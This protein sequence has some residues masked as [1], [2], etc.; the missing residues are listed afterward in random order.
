MS[1]YVK[2]TNFLRKD[3]L[4]DT[5]TDKIIRGS[6]FDTE[7][8]NL[9]TAVASKANTVSPE[10]TG[11]PRA[12]TASTGTSS[13]QIATTAFVTQNAILRGMI[14]MWSGAVDTIPAGYALC[15]GDNDTPDLRNRFVVGAGSTYA[16]DATG[17]SADAIAVT[18][19]HTATTNNTGAH[20]HSLSGSAASA[21]AHTHSYTKQSGSTKLDAG[22]NAGSPY[23][24]I[25]SASGTTGSGGAHT[26]SISGTAASKGNHTHTV[27]VANG[28][29]SGTGKNLPPYYALAYIMKIT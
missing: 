9:V 8:N 14:V 20:T 28:G 5:D 2:T 18:H 6:E 15:D 29:A 3:S 24:S 7:F 22:G 21:G 12:P 26:H 19:S 17:G 25:G 27:T 10:L 1:N 16:V 23:Y 4:P 13:T 11:V